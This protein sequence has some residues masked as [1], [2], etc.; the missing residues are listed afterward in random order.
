LDPIN[1]ANFGT[2]NPDDLALQLSLLMKSRL[3]ELRVQN[4]PL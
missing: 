2:D 1:P 4:S 3:N